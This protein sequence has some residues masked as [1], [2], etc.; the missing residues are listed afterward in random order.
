MC[1]L[2][3]PLLSKMMTCTEQ[4]LYYRQWTVPRSYHMDSSNRTEGRSDNFHP[5]RLLL[6]GPPQVHPLLISVIYPNSRSCFA[7]SFQLFHIILSLARWVRQERTYTSWVFC[8]VCWSG[9]WRW[10]STTKK[11][12]TTVSTLAAVA[13]ISYLSYVNTGSR[14]LRKLVFCICRG[15]SAIVC[16]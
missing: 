11:T 13:A 4:S 12:S 9:W 8:L 7:V 6:S 1:F 16:Q 15:R 3:R 5:R 2:G 10:I 14:L